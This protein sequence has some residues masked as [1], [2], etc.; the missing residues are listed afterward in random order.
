MPRRIFVLLTSVAALASA[1][2]LAAA[3]SSHPRNAAR[4]RGRARS[5]RC[6]TPDKYP[7]RRDP[8][9][10]LMLPAAPGANPLAGANLF[11]DGPRHGIAAG[12]I[13]R[14]QGLDPERYG[15]NVSWWQFYAQLQRGR[16]HRR[17]MRDRALARQV[18]LLAKI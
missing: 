2:T 7:A 14:L 15:D 13:A 18:A 11:V 17:L 9:N 1:P 12:T 3:T 16:L 10:P 4:H 6:A 8:A 5:T